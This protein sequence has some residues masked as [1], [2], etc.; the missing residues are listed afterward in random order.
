MCMYLQCE[1]RL[2][3]KSNAFIQN[4]NYFCLVLQQRMC[5][6][7]CTSCSN[8]SMECQSSPCLC[9]TVKIIFLLVEFVSKYIFIQ[10][11]LLF[12]ES[13]NKSCNAFTIKLPYRLFHKM[14]TCHAD[15]HHVLTRLQ[16][17]CAAN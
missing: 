8:T 11:S 14:S 9:T 15:T 5:L 12:R 16:K 3:Q 2:S 7:T 10:P 17:L 1:T 6:A 13:Y 4:T